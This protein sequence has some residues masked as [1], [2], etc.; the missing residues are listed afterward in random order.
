MYDTSEIAR[1]IKRKIEGTITAEELIKFSELAEENPSIRS[2]L[3]IIEDDHTLLEDTAIYLNLSM[4]EEKVGRRNRLLDKTF[5]KIHKRSKIMLFRKAIP[6]VAAVLV[7][8]LSTLYYYSLE[9]DKL[10]IVL[11]EDLAP[12]SNRASITLADGRVIELSQDQHGVVLNDQLQYED[13]TLIQTMDNS[14]IVHATISTPKGGQYQITLSDGT[15]VWLN[16]DSKLTYP[17]RFNGDNRLVELEGEAYFEVSTVAKKG[18]KAPF[19]V[20]TSFQQVEVLGTQFNL[21]AYPDDPGDTHTT[22]VEGIVSLHVADKTLPLFPGEQGVSN[23]QGISKRRVDVGPYIAWKDNQFVF[24]EIELREAIKILSRWYDFDFNIDNA[25]KPIH[26]YAS[27]NRSKSL[28]EVLNILESSGIKFRLERG[29]ERNK[30]L[31]FN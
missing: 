16:A 18:K 5:A 14:E 6:Y 22:L 19:I 30:L 23:K 31:I 28:K 26:L 4:E 21:K 9:Q 13:G 24:E 2:L 10:D 25:V 17:S 8:S 20:K 1:L 27:I 12:G 29:G 7:L 11:I 3:L 15:K